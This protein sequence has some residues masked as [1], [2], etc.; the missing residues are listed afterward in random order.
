LLSQIEQDGQNQAAGVTN[1]LATILSKYLKIRV[2]TVE[3]K[4]FVEDAPA[5][6]SVEHNLLNRL[7][8]E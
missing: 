3:L 6:I 4:H 7:Q 8:P 5:E 2:K 1:T